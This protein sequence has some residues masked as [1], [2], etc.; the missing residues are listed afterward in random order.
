MTYVV[1]ADTGVL[2]GM[3]QVAVGSTSAALQAA[4]LML[5]Q[6]LTR[7]RVLDTATNPEQSLGK[8]WTQHGGF[9]LPTCRGIPVLCTGPSPTAAPLSLESGTTNVLS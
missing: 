9:V 5:D 4:A 2:G 8:F 6:G 3:I 1:R 7:I